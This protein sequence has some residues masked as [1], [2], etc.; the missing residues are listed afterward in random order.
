MK[1]LRAFTKH[2]LYPSCAIFTL[3]W[4]IVSALVDVVSDVVNI[5]LV[6]GLMCY[7]IAFV[8]ACCNLI[9]KKDSIAFVARFFLH[10]LVT[11]VSISITVAIFSTCFETAYVITGNS[12]Y[13]VLI[14]AVLYLVIATP[15]M[16]I[17]H[18]KHGKSRK[19]EAYQP[20]FRK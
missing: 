2:I 6:S 15:L 9:L 11:V 12:F 1:Y 17:Y 18:K 10:M 7:A 4:F 8:I 13:L 20:M 16:L 19:N 3:I 14:L 5:N